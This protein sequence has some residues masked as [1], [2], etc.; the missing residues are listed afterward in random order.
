MFDSIAGRYDLLNIVLSGGWHKIWESV[1]VRELPRDPDGKCLDLC[2]GTGALIPHLAQRY[3]EVVGVDI[4]S[5]MLSVARKRWGHLGNVVLCEGDALDL[6]YAD[7]EFDAVTIAYGVRNW[8]DFSKGLSEVY[9][10]VRPG[11]SVA[12]LEFG[13]P[14]NPIWRRLFGLY[15]RYVIPALGGLISG[16]RAPYQYLPKTAA[17]FPCGDEFVSVLKQ[18]GFSNV[19]Q[20]SLL[21]GVAYIYIAAK[22]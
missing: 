1:L 14:R 2:T 20:R 17:S 7:S 8:P 11:G 12:I 18:I 19:H 4:S 22:V 15:S 16:T 6:A 21:G 3:R 10:V 5:E 9:R 13:Q